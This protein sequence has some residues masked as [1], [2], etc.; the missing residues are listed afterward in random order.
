M[1]SS[2]SADFQNRMS[3]LKQIAQK[4]GVRLPATIIPEGESLIPYGEDR[5]RA[6]SEDI[7]AL[8]S[9]TE[10]S[11]FIR[12]MREEQKPVDAVVPLQGASASPRFRFLFGP[13]FV[14]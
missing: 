14:A 6:L 12:E 11:T 1:A 8:P 4:T 10:A 3:V 5:K 13:P 2:T 7:G 9:I